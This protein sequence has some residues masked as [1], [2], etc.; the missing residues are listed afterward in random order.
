MG[1]LRGVTHGMLFGAAVALLYAPKPGRELRQELAARFERLRSQVQP[2]MEQAQ[3]VVDASRP[4]LEKT[5]SKAQQ[6]IIR[7]RTEPGTGS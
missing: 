2:V 1:Y 7:R 5:I 3:E 4:S 6:R